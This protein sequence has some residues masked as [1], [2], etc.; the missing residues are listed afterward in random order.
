MDRPIKLKCDC[1][2]PKIHGLTWECSCGIEH[3]MPK[4]HWEAIHWDEENEG[5]PP[6]DTYIVALEIHKEQWPEGYQ[7]RGFQVN[8]D[9][10]GNKYFSNGDGLGEG[11]QTPRPREFDYWMLAEDFRPFLPSQP[12]EK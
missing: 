9:N 6:D 4:C 7:I 3:V 1:V 11:W 10:N 2:K 12:K 5:L 8:T